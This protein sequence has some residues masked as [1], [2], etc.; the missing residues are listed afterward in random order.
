MD[1]QSLV[2]L[3]RCR[4]E[5]QIVQAKVAAA[6]ISVVFED[7]S[8]VLTHLLS[9]TLTFARLVPVKGR[10]DAVDLICMGGQF[11]VTETAEA[12]VHRFALS[13]YLH[14]HF[15]PSVPVM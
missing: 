7:A 12:R 14:F 13:P 1:R 4:T 6:V 11:E 5:E 8:V 15:L 2:W 10:P 9:V 3:R